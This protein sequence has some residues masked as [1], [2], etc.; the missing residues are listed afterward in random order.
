MRLHRDTQIEDQN[1][2]NTSAGDHRGQYAHDE[3]ADHG[4]A[5][6]AIRFFLGLGLQAGGELQVVNAEHGQRQQQQHY[7][8]R[9]QEKRMRS[10]GLQLFS[11]G[12]GDCPGDG[13][14]YGCT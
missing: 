13:P 5:L 11:R 8:D 9:D 3:D 6:E 14:D 2:G 10:I 4:A 1:R 12:T 7:R